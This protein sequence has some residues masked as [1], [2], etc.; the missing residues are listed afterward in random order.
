MKTIAVDCDDVIVPFISTI[1]KF[2]NQ[3]YGSTL[4]ENHFKSYEF[5]RVWSGTEERAIEKVKEFQKSDMFKK[6]IP[7]EESR[8]IIPALAR[9]YNLV[10]V[11]ARPDYMLEETQDLLDT[12]FP[13]SF[14]EIH[15]T[16]EWAGNGKTRK[17]SQICK[18]I[19][20]E[21]IIEDSHANAIDCAKSG[22]QAILINK[23]WNTSEET[24]PNLYRVNNWPEIP[25]L[26]AHL[27]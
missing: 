23:P 10:L 20:A 12:Y 16:N 22:I 24:H 1:A 21:L 7:Y 3:E 15:F 17:K 9:R 2:H 6:M 8:R 11:T 4:E 5:W 27:L 25:G 18:E 14:S 13:N 19:K 26:V